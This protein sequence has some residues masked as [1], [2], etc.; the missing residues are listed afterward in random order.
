MSKKL[1]PKQTPMR[2]T[3][4]PIRLTK[5]LPV[6][7]FGKLIKHIGQ[8]DVEQIAFNSVVRLL[9]KH[10]VLSEMEI[11][12]EFLDEAERKGL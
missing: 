10:G 4:S 5:A 11:Q 8:M 9:V 1:S 7:E 3:Q 2:V 6:R 12:Q